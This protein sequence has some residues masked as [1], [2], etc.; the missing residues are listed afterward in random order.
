MISTWLV[1]VVWVR[2]ALPEQLMLVSKWN[3]AS[4]DQPPKYTLIQSKECCES[5]RCKQSVKNEHYGLWSIF[6]PMWVTVAPAFLLGGRST[7]SL[8]GRSQDLFHSS[9]QQQVFFG[10]LLARQGLHR[11]A[12]KLLRVEA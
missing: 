1:R 11:Q 10:F 4:L 3:L 8:S 12:D 7:V 6:H 9:L 5:R 2:V